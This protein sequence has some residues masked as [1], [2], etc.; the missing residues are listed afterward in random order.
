MAVAAARVGVF[1]AAYPRAV[2]MRASEES[3][4]ADQK[5]R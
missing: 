4:F 3:V 1:L 5:G 2:K